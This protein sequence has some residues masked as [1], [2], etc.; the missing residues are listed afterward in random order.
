MDQGEE[1]VVPA[2]PPAE[3]YTSVVPGVVGVFFVEGTDT[4]AARQFIEGL[5]L[6]FQFP[7]TGSPLLGVVVVPVATEDAWVARLKTY[8]VVKAADR[9]YVTVVSEAIPPA[10]SSG[11]R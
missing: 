3:G 2:M 8:S 11:P 1:P 9:V 10:Q 5:G 6:S 4:S 7:P